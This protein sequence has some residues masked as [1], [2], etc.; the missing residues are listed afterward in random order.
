MK[1]LSMILLTLVLTLCL[2]LSGLPASAENL[3]AP[4]TADEVQ[5]TLAEYAA[6]AQTL[7]PHSVTRDVEDPQ[8]GYILTYEDGFAVFADSE[9]LTADTRVKAMILYSD[10]LK[11]PRGSKTETN[12]GDFLRLFRS[13]NDGLAGSYTSA[14]VYSL[15]NPME[16]FSCCLVSRSGQKILNIL[17]TVAEETE[18]G[19]LFSSM[20]CY[21]DNGVVSAIMLDRETVSAEEAA[22]LYAQLHE[23]AEDESYHAVPVNYLDGSEL[24]PFE[25]ADLT[26]AG[27]NFL[28]ATPGDLPG[29]LDEAWD[30]DGADGWMHRMSGDG[31]SAVFKADKDRQNERLSLLTILDERLEGPRCL[32]IGDSVIETTGRF[33]YE[34]TEFDYENMSQLLYG[35]TE[36]VPYGLAEYGEDGS[37]TVRYTLRTESGETVMLIL[38]YRDMTLNEILV[39]LL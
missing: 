2:C 25:E 1:K 17:Y 16:G 18:E 14:L 29:L 30:E 19:F 15:G 33:Y 28:T 11:G 36:G 5:A 35:S 23:E 12:T 39:T 34:A 13:D 6:L 21:V 4:L 3:P 20:S 31:W 10:L 8:G 22:E 27:I 9:A 26:F 24:D 7:T 37:A 32:R 38:T